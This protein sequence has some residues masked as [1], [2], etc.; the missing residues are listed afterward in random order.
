M[1]SE[2]LFVALGANRYRVER[3][4]GALPGGPARVSDVAAGPDGTLLA[5]LRRD[6]LVDPPTPAVVALAADG[7]QLASWGAEVAD[8]HKLARHPDGRVFVVDRD[9]HEVV[10]FSPAGQRLG[11]LGHRH[12]PGEPFNAP[13]AI[14][15]GAD[16]GCYVADGYGNALVHRFG[17]DGVLLQSWGGPGRRAGEFTTPH[18]IAVLADGRVAV[19]DRDNNRVQLF[20][21]EGRHLQDISDL[22]RPMALAAT[23]AGGLLVTDQVPRLSLYNAEGRLVGRCRPVLQ[24]AHGVALGA[25]GSIWLAEPNPNRLTRLLPA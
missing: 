22:P 14:A 20:T 12:A 2:V 16:G 3:P 5:L 21:P 11:G 9:A 25:N 24:G 8:A 18:A 4:F 19:A 13:T 7:Q 10:I 15:F 17:A 1:S 23:P 6:P